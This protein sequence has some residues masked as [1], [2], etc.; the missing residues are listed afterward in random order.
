LRIAAGKLEEDKIGRRVVQ[1]GGQASGE[2]EICQVVRRSVRA[3]TNATSD[4]N[5]PADPALR[6]AITGMMAMKM[7]AKSLATSRIGPQEKSL[8]VRYSSACRFQ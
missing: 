1:E 8:P 3:V 6:I 4:A 5:A 2:P 7:P